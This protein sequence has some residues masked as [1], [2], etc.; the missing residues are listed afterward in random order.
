MDR[1]GLHFKMGELFSGPGG[2]ALGADLAIEA[3]R[4]FGDIDLVHEW[5]ND[6][7][8]DTCKTYLRNIKIKKQNVKCKDV[9]KLRI[10]ELTP[11]NAFSF[12]FPCNDYSTVGEQKGTDGTYGPL[13]KY[14]VQVLKEFQPDWFLAENVSGLRNA[15]DGRDF[16]KI[17][18]ELYYAGYDLYPNMYRFEEYGV[19]QARHRL[20]IIG[21]RKD[22]KVDFRIPAPSY[23][24]KTCKEAI[25]NPPIPSDVPNNELTIQN[26]I[27]IERLRY[28]K[29]G[30]NAFTADL[31]E[32]LQL[33]VKG[34]KISQIY[35]RLDPE[36]PAYT[37]TGSGGGGTHMYHWS[38]NRALTNR[39]R[40]RIQTFPD[41]FTFEGG[42][43]S[44][45]KQIGMAVPPQGAKMV[46]EAIFKTLMGVDYDSIEAN[47][48]AMIH[49]RP[50]SSNAP[51]HEVSVSE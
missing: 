45:R 27:V 35:R 46:F 34:A 1:P 18:Q 33:N 5:A 24:L 12:G 21:F 20:I 37:L 31:P 10:S 14:G 23:R 26:K 9:R 42:K 43:E 13:Y 8:S 50:I 38:E 3:V 47:M 16:E 6:F 29:P 4:Q 19:P 25:E 39:E 49:N 22:M 48:E 30:E 2:I 15:N 40:A 11:I 32:H 44:V 17:L 7:D 28:I 41:S 36:K 51:L